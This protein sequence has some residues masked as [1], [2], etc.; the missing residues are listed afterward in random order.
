M[1]ARVNWHCPI[2]VTLT[3]RMELQNYWTRHEDGSWVK[4]KQLWLALTVKAVSD[5]GPQVLELLC[6]WHNHITLGYFRG[7]ED[8]VEELGGDPYGIADYLERRVCRGR[9][10][11]L[12]TTNVYCARSSGA[13]LLSIGGPLA[14]ALELVQSR[15]LY[16]LP[17]QCW[18]RLRL[19]RGQ[20]HMQVHPGRA[21]R[22]ATV[23]QLWFATLRLR[24]D[25]QE[26]VRRG[27]LDSLP[28][29]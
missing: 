24:A 15:V 25:H 6:P 22:D 19:D 16:Q 14:V 11:K 7:D 5:A 9:S 23:E 10:W 18:Q 27:Y 4:G 17:V 3:P 21:L 28:Y 8:L 13:V 12:D 2:D 1:W 20:L 26:M 29:S